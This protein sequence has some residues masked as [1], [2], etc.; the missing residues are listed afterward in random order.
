MLGARVA[1]GGLRRYHFARGAFA[2]ATERSDSE[3]EELVGF[4]IGHR[5]LRLAA[6]AH[7]LPVLFISA[8]S[9]PTC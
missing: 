7:H 8:G 3:V 9:P 4:Q 5:V 6:D 2:H 1:L